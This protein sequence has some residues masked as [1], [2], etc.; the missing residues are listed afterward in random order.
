M[1]RLPHPSAVL[2]CACA[3]AA[4][5][6]HAELKERVAGVV[7]GQPIT[8]SDVEER[9]ALELQRL[10]TTGEARQK[11]RLDLLKRGLDQ[12]VDERL[13]EAEATNLG[14]EVSDEEVNRQVEALAKQ[15]GL[16]TN[17]FKSALA[18]QGVDFGMV[19]DSLRRQ[20]L[21]FRLL[22]Y[23]VKPRKVSD[24]EVQAAY[25][26]QAGEGE[27]EIR[28]RNLFIAAPTG[29]APEVLAKA[30]AKAE[31]AVRRLAAGEEFAV[32]ARDLSEIPNAHEGGDLGWVRRGTLFPEADAALFALQ[33]GKTSSLLQNP[34]GY[35]LFH[36][37]DRRAVM[38]KPLA[39]VQEEIRARLANDSIMKERENYLKALR[40][41]AQIELKL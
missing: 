30:K 26:A 40:K 12:L 5:P 4:L 17:G 1:P 32:V 36:A 34:G 2:L 20:A 16:D 3:L 22:Q 7:N 28:A 37:S 29:G 11:E 10:T 6:A 8:L 24:E 9:I 38:A 15:N 33:P 41:G 31:T 23:K 13:I 25:A 27:V 21:Q 35:H 39:E 14:V 19:K 18:A